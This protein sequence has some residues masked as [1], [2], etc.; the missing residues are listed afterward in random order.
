MIGYIV[1]LIGMWIL[2]DSVLL[3]RVYADV[4]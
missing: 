3:D 1:G 4:V 2:A